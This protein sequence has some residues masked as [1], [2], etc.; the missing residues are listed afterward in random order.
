LECGAAQTSLRSLRKLDCVATCG[1]S[2]FAGGG[3]RDAQ[4]MGCKIIVNSLLFTMSLDFLPNSCACDDQAANR[5]RRGGMLRS[6]LAKRTQGGRSWRLSGPDQTPDGL[7][8][9]AL[10]AANSGVHSSFRSSSAPVSLHIRPC[11]FG[12]VLQVWRAIS[13]LSAFRRPHLQGSTEDVSSESRAR[14]GRAGARTE[15]PGQALGQA[16]P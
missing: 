8:Q 1:R 9:A 13:Q 6:I 11:Y 3:D 7:Q 15:W 10:A 5:T 16:R 4:P 2:A 12:W 14:Q